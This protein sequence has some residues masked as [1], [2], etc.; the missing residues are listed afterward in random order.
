MLFTDRVVTV[1]LLTLAAMCFSPGCHSSDSPAPAGTPH[2]TTRPE[3]DPADF[4]AGIPTVA[5]LAANIEASHG[6]SYA[7]YD[8]LYHGSG[9]VQS[10]PYYRLNK[11]GNVCEYIA[12]WEAANPDPDDLAF[13]IYPFVI[14]GYDRDPILYYNWSDPPADIGDCWV[15][16]ANWS[17]QRWDWRKCTTKGYLA[18]NSFDPYFSS[19]HFFVIIVAACNKTCTFD[20]LQVGPPQVFPTVDAYPPVSLPPAHITATAAGSTTAVGDIANYE[21]DWDGDG[22][23]EEDTADSPYSSRDVT[24]LGNHDIAVR[25]TTDYGIQAT[26]SGTYEVIDGWAHSWGGE[27]QEWFKDLVSI[28]S[29][30]YVLG[31]GNSF[32]STSFDIFLLKYDHH[33]NYY[34]ARGWGGT[35]YEQ[36]TAVTAI[37]GGD[38][39]TTGITTSFGA[40]NNDIFL[41]RWDSAGNLLWTT[42]WGG[43]G[44]DRA[45]DVQTGGEHIYVT[46]ETTSFGG[47]MKD[48]VL[49]KFDHSGDLVWQRTWGGTENDSAHSMDMSYQHF[50]DTYSAHLAG[51]T[52]SFG[53]AWASNSI[54]YL[55]FTENGD[56]SIAQLWPNETNIP[57]A[58]IEVSGMSGSEVYLAGH[59]DSGTGSELLFLEYDSGGDPVAVSWGGGTVTDYANDLYKLGND[60]LLVGGGTGYADHSTG[61][62]VNLSADGALQGA[63]AWQGDGN[64]ALNMLTYLGGTGFVACGSS[65]SASGSFIPITGTLTPIDRD[66][67]GLAQTEQTPAGITGSPSGTVTNITSAVRDTGGGGTRDC[68]ICAATVP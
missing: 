66:W 58:D 14:D 17:E 48:V 67:T 3:A 38:I 40:G 10:F 59:R 55:K 20:F 35:D 61:T 57:D 33:G 25:V 28:S 24:E 2:P 23:F 46:G 39:I 44:D 31:S 53:P 16:L 13:G 6:T 9:F 5:E 18:Y 22:I 41:Q 64:S 65:N 51:T 12:A 27:G 32:T 47:G 11:N 68:F 54:V 30:I 7:E 37:S 36:G 63:M 29:G 4:S 45:R 52:N 60:Y 56:V 34:W 49:L 62:I 15:G 21:W 8:L 42:T 26:G 50:G 19:G 43:A 1:M